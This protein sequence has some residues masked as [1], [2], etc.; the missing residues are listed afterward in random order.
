M[1]RRCQGGFYTQPWDYDAP[2]ETLA[3]LEPDEVLVQYRHLAPGPRVLDLGMGDGDHALW[4]A[5]LGYDVEGVDWHQRRLGQAEIR[6]MR[7]KLPLQT[8]LGDITEFPIAPA[9]Y[10]LILLAAVLHFLP[11]S[12]HRRVA[13]Q[14]VQ[15]LRPGGLVYATALTTDDPGYA[16]VRQA[17]LPELEP[18]TFDLSDDDSLELLHFF[19]PGGLRD[20]FAGLE[21]VYYA[22]ERYLRPDSDP[23]FNAAAVLLARRPSSKET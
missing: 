10:D 9:A 22:E 11:P 3:D 14:V 17:G 12:D 18:N 5:S 4:L 19:P 13:E 20:L 16:L 8:Y 2:R 21:V 23:G 6:A 15:G 1:P 7:L